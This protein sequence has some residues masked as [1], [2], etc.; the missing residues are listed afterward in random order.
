ML[1][2]TRRD[3]LTTLAGGMAGTLSIACRNPSPRA[4]AANPG[5]GETAPAYGEILKFDIHSHVFE[6]LPALADMLRRN[7]FRTMNIC[8][9]GTDGHLETMHRIAID[10][11]GKYP[12]LFAFASTFD[13]TRINQPGY[14][15]D[16]IRW[17][18]GTFKNGAVA[19]K[20]W[21]DV[22]LTVKKPDG[23]Y[24][25][26]DDPIFDPI[27][28]HLAKRGKP[29]LAHLAEPIAAWL[30]L[31][32][33]SPHHHYYSTHPEWHLYGKPE[34]PSHAAIIAARDHILEKHPALTLIGAHLGSLETDLDA[35]AQRLQ[36]YPNFNIECAARTR[37]LTRHRSEKVRALFMRYPDRILYGLDGAWQ[38]YLRDKPP[39]DAERQAYIKRLDQRYRQDYDYYAGSGTMQYDGWPVEKL[40]LPRTVLEKFYN[41]NARRLIAF[42][43]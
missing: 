15:G 10:L 14:T 24:F 5:A 35:I 28:A 2:L 37:D 22:G 11:C 23:M 16:V 12:D 25:L 31:D 42:P 30:P 36:R 13:L 3:A 43:G 20:I 17:L 4:P 6:D 38:P 19:T 41:Q 26:P 32:P 39:T 40:A 1:R 8:N 33:K 21:K 27:Y 29:L 18:D 9:N 7:N 34:Y